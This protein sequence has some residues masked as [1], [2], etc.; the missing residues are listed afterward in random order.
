MDRRRTVKRRCLPK[1]FDLKQEDFFVLK[2]EERSNTAV[3]QVMRQTKRENILF[4]ESLYSDYFVYIITQVIRFFNQAKRFIF[5][6][7]PAVLGDF[8]TNLPFVGVLWRRLYEMC[9]I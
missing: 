8:V 9:Q 4:Q 5:V 6:N 2:V 3:L 7:H 1:I